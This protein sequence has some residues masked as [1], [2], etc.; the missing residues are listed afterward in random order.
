MDDRQIKLECLRIAR[1]TMSTI[2]H[3]NVESVLAEAKKLYEWVY[4]K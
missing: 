1:N 3:I 4:S 2:E